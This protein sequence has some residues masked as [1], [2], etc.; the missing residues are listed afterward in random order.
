M[1]E[2]KNPNQM[3]LYDIAKTT[4]QPLMLKEHFRCVPDIIGYSNGLSYDYKIKPLRD[5]SNVAVKPATISY[6]V[7]GHRASYS[8]TNEEEAKNIV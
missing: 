5:D 2:I 3:N 1:Q 7:N 4:F 6:R 8:K